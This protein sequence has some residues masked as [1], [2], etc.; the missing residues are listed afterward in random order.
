M[1]LI[2]DDTNTQEVL[3]DIKEQEMVLILLL[4]KIDDTSKSEFTSLL[5]DHSKQTNY[6]ADLK[7]KIH[8][9]GK[10][11]AFHG[12]TEDVQNTDLKKL[13]PTKP[14]D[15]LVDKYWKLFSVAIIKLLTQQYDKVTVYVF[16]QN[17]MT[18]HEENQ[19]NLII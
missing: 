9:N 7:N 11:T 13:Y 4:P 3:D 14:S 6:I 12:D 1:Y 16:T 19:K 8:E 10:Y 17:D 15:N 2:N 5:G 18:F